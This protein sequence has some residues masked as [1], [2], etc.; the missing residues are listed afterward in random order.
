[1]GKYRGVDSFPGKYKFGGYYDSERVT[2]QESQTDGYGTWGLYTL[3]EQMLYAENDNY[4]EG[5]SV[6]FSLSY[7]PPSRNLIKF[8]AAGGLSYQGL[9]P[10]RPQDALALVGAYGRYSNALAR[11]Q[12]ARGE[13]VQDFELL[14]EANYRIQVAPW[15]F[16]QPS[17]QGVIHPGGN[18]GVP[19]AMVIGF[20]FGAT[21]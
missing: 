15:I 4:N 5:L 8:M 10:G 21:L 12:R 17:V 14:L 3:A 1:V 6:F 7:A 19:D 20:A 11:G 13:T 9:I 16:L 2:N 18:G